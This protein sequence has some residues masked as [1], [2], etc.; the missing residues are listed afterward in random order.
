M[1]DH[2]HLSGKAAVS[3]LG[4]M[5]AAFALLILALFAVPA[6]TASAATAGP[7]QVAATCYGGSTAVTLPSRGYSRTFTTSTRCLDI[8][9]KITSGGGGYVAVCFNRTNKCQS[10]FT[11]IPQNRHYHVVASNVLN[12]T[13][14]YFQ[15]YN[16]GTRH[17]RQAS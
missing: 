7:E 12:G 17:G 16:S 14:F 8:N 9:L 6:T 10:R 1:L 5:L 4:A 11:Y 13:K 3:K 15:L 2:S